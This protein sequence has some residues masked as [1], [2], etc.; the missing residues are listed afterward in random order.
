M[1]A[2]PKLP[3]VWYLNAYKTQFACLNLC[4]YTYMYVYYVSQLC[5]FMTVSIMHA[6][7]CGALS[8]PPNGSVTTPSGTTAGNVAFYSCDEGLVLTG[9]TVRV[10]GND[11]QWTPTTPTCEGE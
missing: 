5:Y 9:S 6:V 8:P 1:H 3:K 2:V 10:C 7:D 11:G 4:K